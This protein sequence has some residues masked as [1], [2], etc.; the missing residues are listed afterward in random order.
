MARTY[1]CDGCDLITDKPVLRITRTDGFSGGGIRIWT[2]KPYDLC[3]ACSVK[4]SDAIGAIKT[5]TTAR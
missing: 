3:G 4:I 1:R 5:G 2:D